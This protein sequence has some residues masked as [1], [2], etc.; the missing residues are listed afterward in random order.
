MQA[1][2]SHLE[3]PDEA[4][5]W[6]GMHCMLAHTINKQEDISSIIFYYESNPTKAVQQN[7]TAA[8][9]LQKQYVVMQHFESLNI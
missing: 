3:K 7:V 5:T 4:A 1:P 6:Y 2:Y 8:L 9:L